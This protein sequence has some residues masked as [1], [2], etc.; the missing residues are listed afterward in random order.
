MSLFIDI[1]NLQEFKNKYKCICTAFIDM[2][3]EFYVIEKDYDNKNW[4][5]YV[6]ENKNKNFKVA[7]K[8]K[9]VKLNIFH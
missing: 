4:A 8:D 7:M 2:N 3:N 6:L 5:E 9:M 1:N